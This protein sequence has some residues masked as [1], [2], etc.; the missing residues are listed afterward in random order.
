MHHRPRLN[1]SIGGAL[2][3][4]SSVRGCYERIRLAA[5]HAVLEG[6]GRE[7][8][9]RRAR[10]NLRRVATAALEATHAT[11]ES[12]RVANPYARPA[13]DAV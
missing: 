6:G 4:D 3:T 10:R 1:W 13:R 9:P 11:L 12:Q 2:S 7:H 5:R 8:D